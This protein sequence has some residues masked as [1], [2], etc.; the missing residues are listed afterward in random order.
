MKKKKTAVI[1]VLTTLAV[2]TGMMLLTA[3]LLLPAVI[4]TEESK[5]GENVSGIEYGSAPENQAL[6]ITDKTGRGALI[7]LDF[8]NIVTH[9]YLF[10]KDSEKEAVNIPYNVNYTIFIE[11]DF[12]GKFCDRIGG[13]DIEEEGETARYFS[14]SLNEYMGKTPSEEKMLKISRSFFEKIANTGLS[15]ED[16][17]FIIEETDTVLPYSV[18]YGWIDRIPEMFCNCIFH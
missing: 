11:S 9:I 8:D 5:A 14:A 17:M 10:S 13:I 16:F 6:L 18:C 15:S 7:Y 2:C 4:G 3:I 12:A 1:T